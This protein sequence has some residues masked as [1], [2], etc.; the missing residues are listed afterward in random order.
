MAPD[1][2]RYLFH[3]GA[4]LR[5]P[6]HPLAIALNPGASFCIYT[7]VYVALSLWEKNRSRNE[8]ISWMRY[9]R[10]YKLFLS[11]ATL[12]LIL[13]SGISY[14]WIRLGSNVRNNLITIFI[15]VIWTSWWIKIS[16]LWCHY[17]D[18][19]WQ[20]RASVLLISNFQN[21]TPHERLFDV[22]GRS[23]SSRSRNYEGV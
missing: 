10:G 6:F 23:Q 16:I 8:I 22:H 2:D 19:A 4:P 21:L 15:I 11:D 1:A 9:N 7:Y 13:E 20:I 12:L 3:S 17:R 5:P 14:S 18:I